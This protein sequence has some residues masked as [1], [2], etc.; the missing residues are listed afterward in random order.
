M[1]IRNARID[2]RDT[3]LHIF[4]S[5]RRFMQAT[6]NPHQWIDGYPSCELITR[7]IAQ[8]HCYVL[9]DETAGVTATFSFLPGPD[10]TYARIYDGAWPNDRPY[11]VIH[12]LASDGAIKG[13]AALC[14]DWCAA[15]CTDLRADTHQD[16]RVMQHLLKKNGF[17]PCGTIISAN[18]TPRIAFQRSLPATNGRRTS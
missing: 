5:A 9:E 8:G 4:D 13:V 11:G 2:D 12:R 10:P 15:R 7:D 6:G 1:Y 3:L 17:V 16:N 14:F 18:G